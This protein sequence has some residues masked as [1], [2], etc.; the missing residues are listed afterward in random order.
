MHRL[1]AEINS[2]SIVS[3]ARELIA[4]PTPV[5]STGEGHEMEAANALA[6]RLRSSCF[7]VMLQDVMENRPNL[8]AMLQGK[9][10]GQTLML[11]GHLDTV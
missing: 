10:G 2:D 8:I 9:G 6:R 1:V 4:L 3:L 5:T 11:N 7:K